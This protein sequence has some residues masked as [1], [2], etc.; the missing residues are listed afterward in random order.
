MLTLLASSRSFPR[1]SKHPQ[2]LQGWDLGV[3]NMIIDLRN[4]V[5]G[6]VWGTLLLASLLSFIA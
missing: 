2:H 6:V 1:K 3:E 4:I 5:R